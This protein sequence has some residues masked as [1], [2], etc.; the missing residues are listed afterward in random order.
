MPNNYPNPQDPNHLETQRRLDRA[1]DLNRQERAAEANGTANGLLLGS[2][3]V[4][5]IGL[6]SLAAY[7]WS[8]PA[9]APTTIINT[10]PTP[11]ASVSPAPQKTTIIDRTVEKTTPPKVKVVEVEKPVAVPVPTT[12][13]VVE[14]PKP[15]IVPG[16]TKVIEVPAK[17]T[18]T[19]GVP[20]PTDRS[21][22][23]PNTSPTP[24]AQPST[25]TSEGTDA[26]T[27]PSSPTTA[28]ANN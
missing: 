8:R 11:A 20:N 10:T 19:T 28:P 21:A 25:P 24:A 15:I 23:P 17:P 18:P 9:P 7:Y 4:G 3:F 22:T 27:S 12:P 2:L 16:A 6:G 26:N 14:V 1:D 5:L 13:K